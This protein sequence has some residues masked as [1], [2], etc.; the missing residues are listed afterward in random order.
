MRNRNKENLIFGAT[1][2]LYMGYVQ[3]G[4]KPK[5]TD[6]VC[7]FKITP[8]GGV[9]VREAAA[10]VAA[11]SSVG[12]WVHVET[13]KPYV[14]RLA[15]KVF[16]IRGNIVKVAYPGELFESNNIPQI[17]SSIAGNIFGMKIVD[18]LRLEDINLPKQ[19]IGS[20]DGPKFGI[21]GIRKL[22]GVRSRPLLGTIVKPKLGLVTKDHASVA[23]DAWLGG[24]DIVK[25]DENLSS[26]HFNPFKKRITETLK[27]RDRAE[28]ETGEKKIY[29]PNVTA[30][31]KTMLERARYVKSLGGEYVMVD[32]ITTG[33]SSLQTLREADLN[34]V[35]HAHRAMHGAFTRPKGHGISMLTIAKL[36]RLVGMDQLHIGTV[37]GKMEGGVHEV[38]DTEEEI[39][40]RLIKPHGHMLAENWR[41]IKPTFAVCSG[42]LHP[43][44]IPALVQMLGR[45]II[46]QCGGGIHGHPDGTVAG[47]TA[48]RQ[49]ID[50]VME[51]VSLKNYA[52]SHRE[53]AAALSKFGKAREGYE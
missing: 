42:G 40:E 43:G 3:L 34:L 10:A 11:E 45:D 18:Q 35:L 1:Y 49:A 51:G 6:L 4:Y 32:I 21:A 28:R 44:H 31:T 27:M 24:C 23:Y 30:E 41:H 50:A 37:V 20:F 33:W 48:A 7:E 29:M 5:S 52:K 19:V 25:D 13:A 46:I 12:T 8:A 15:A 2:N 38:E 14:K 26:L 9:G 17:L 39:E 36:A 16:E 47:A 53:L 22:M